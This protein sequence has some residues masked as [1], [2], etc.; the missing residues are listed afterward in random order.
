MITAWPYDPTSLCEHSMSLSYPTANHPLKGC[1]GNDAF[2]TSPAEEAPLPLALAPTND[3]MSIA[4]TAQA[5][6][7]LV[8]VL[9]SN[10]DNSSELQAET[11]NLEG[12]V[13]AHVFE[14]SIRLF[15]A[16]AEILAWG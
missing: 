6:A 10:S 5:W 14:N 13:D 7:L 3:H 8:P 16:S 4:K 12:I 15:A 9:P 11:S 2:P 1:A